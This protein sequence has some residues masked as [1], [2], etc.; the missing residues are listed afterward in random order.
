MQ[1]PAASSQGTGLALGIECSPLRRKVLSVQFAS[2]ES[3][4]SFFALFQLFSVEKNHPLL[5]GR[6]RQEKRGSK[7]PGC[8]DFITKPPSGL[9][10][11][12]SVCPAA[13]LESVL[14]TCLP[15]LARL[16][17]VSYRRGHT[18]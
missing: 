5:G 11:V 13:T 16:I 2:T 12:P 15:A 4:G 3:R 9:T 10:S 17:Y 1:A 8:R 6:G 18:D 14:G 7:D